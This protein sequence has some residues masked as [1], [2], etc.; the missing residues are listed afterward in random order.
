MIFFEPDTGLAR[1]DGALMRKLQETE[2]N[3]G[4]EENRLKLDFQIEDRRRW[5]FSL[6]I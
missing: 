3:E 6:Q 2:G 5:E 4:R 1:K